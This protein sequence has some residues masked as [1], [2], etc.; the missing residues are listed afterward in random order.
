MEG[1]LTFATNDA[2]WIP[3]PVIGE[4]QMRIYRMTRG[5]TISGKPRFAAVKP[6]TTDGTTGQ[7]FTLQLW[8]TPDAV[9]TLTYR[10]II[11]ASQLTQG[12]PYPYG[13]M[14]HAE[15]LKESC[16]SMAELTMSDEKG[17][18]WDRFMERLAASISMDRTAGQSRDY[19]GY[20]RD[21]SDLHERG[22]N[23]MYPR[24]LGCTVN[25]VQY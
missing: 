23:T 1:D 15:T 4:A 17:V 7:R 10:K 13:G 14:M 24:T 21:S 19:F 18:H 12:N 8:P 5:A 22:N 11:L 2:G 16:L 3:I 25:G 6:N 9:Y 20:N